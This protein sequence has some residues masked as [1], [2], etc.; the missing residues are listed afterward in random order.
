ME[1]KLYNG[2]NRK[3]PK[4]SVAVDPEKFK[5][6]IKKRGLSLSE[7]SRDLGYA[8]NGVVSAV[9]YG[10]FSGQLV[11]GLRAVYNIEPEKYQYIPPK[12]EP[13]EEPKP[14]AEQPEANTVTVEDSALY[15]TMKKAIMDA[16]ADTTGFYGKW[17]HNIMKQ[18]M[19]EAL[20]G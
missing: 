13:K 4:T 1:T 5:A 18:A 17:L 15:A 2:T 12:E 10:V 16:M 6:L 3:I 11:V 19:Q 20:K 14:V 8:D 7:M 9:R